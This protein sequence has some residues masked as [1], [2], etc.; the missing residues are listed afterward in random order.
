MI[1]VTTETDTPSTIQ[2]K[3]SHVCLG[4]VENMARSRRVIRNSFCHE[5]KYTESTK[6]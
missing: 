5:D 4:F 2:G 3:N 1:A 6:A